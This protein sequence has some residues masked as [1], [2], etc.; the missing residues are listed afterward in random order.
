MLLLVSCVKKPP[1]IKPDTP[2]VS[3]KNVLHD[4]STKNPPQTELEIPPTN[5][6]GHI[7]LYGESHGKEKILAK[8]LEL[9]NTYY[10]DQ[11]MRHLFIE[12]PYYTAEFLNIWMQS[13]DDEIL[14]AIH[15][16]GKGTASDVPVVKEFYQKIKEQCPETIFH[17]TDVGHQASSTGERF[18][19]YLKEKGLQ[20]SDQ[21]KR[22][23]LVMKQG[24]YYYK[25]K[26]EG[27]REN[28]MAENFIYAFN[29]V[30]DEQIMGIYGAA[31]T[32]LE[33]MDYTNT[34]PSMANQLRKYY[35]DV[36]DSEDLS[37]LMKETIPH[38]SDVFVVLGKEYEASYFGIQNLNFKGYAFREFWRLE[39]AYE[40]FKDKLKTSD[41]LPYN[42][43]PM[44]I[45]TGQILVIDYTKTD[46]TTQRTYYRSDGN[47]W[48]G[49]P[50]TEEFRLE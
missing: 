4:E 8:E 40:D 25:N 48:Q 47:A 28:T 21:Y 12:S 27:Y 15:R 10:H 46:G 37:L 22:A 34:V 38:R 5:V 3:S 14:E 50:A 11:N 32:G 7:Y 44:V 29:R 45:E 1:Q 23:Q 13:A 2:L 39:H 17:G 6:T 19:R 42:N 24:Y 43:Y 18:L 16:D 35:G 31:H 33:S 26:D 49:M 30:S 20:N 9:W 36:I 41:V